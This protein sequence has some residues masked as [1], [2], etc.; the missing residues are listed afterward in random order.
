[1]SHEDRLTE[2]KPLHLC[3]IGWHLYHVWSAYEEDK[4]RREATNAKKIYY[5]HRAECDKCSDPP[6]KE[7]GV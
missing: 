5:N 3:D 2:P 7:K 1:M 6:T 4:K